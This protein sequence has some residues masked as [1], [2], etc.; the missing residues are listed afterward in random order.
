MWYMNTI[1]DMLEMRRQVHR[2]RKRWKH[3]RFHFLSEWKEAND[4][5]D[6]PIRNGVVVMSR[7]RC[8]SRQGERDLG[9][10]PARR[11]SSGNER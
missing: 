6:A 9:D 4:D 1:V 2:R 7:S 5:L 11:R 3:T 8:A 10:D